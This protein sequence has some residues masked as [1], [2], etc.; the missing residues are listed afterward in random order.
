MSCNCQKGKNKD[1]VAYSSL[2]PD[3]FYKGT[4]VMGPD[5][6]VRTSNGRTKCESNKY[7]GYC[8]KTEK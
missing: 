3:C 7:Y 8:E 1:V 6:K 4:K 5:G 2:N